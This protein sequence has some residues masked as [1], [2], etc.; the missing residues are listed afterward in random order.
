MAELTLDTQLTTQQLE[1]V[2]LIK[3]STF[4]LLTIINDILDFSKI[5]SGRFHLEEIPFSLRDTFDDAIRALA[6]QAAEKQVELIYDLRPDVPDSLIGDPGRLRQILNNLVGNA[7]KFTPEGEILVRVEM[8]NP[9]D[10]GPCTLHIEVRDTG[11]GIP[12]EKLQ[13]IFEAFRQVDSSTS[14]VYGGTGL[15]LAISS[16]LVEQM[17]G[18]MWVR[19][20]PGKGS[21][22]H[23]RVRLPTAPLDVTRHQDID[24]A[25]LAG[26]TALVIDDN[27]LNLEIFRETLEGWNIRVLSTTNAQAGIEQLRTAAAQGCPF[28][29]LLLDVVMPGMDG[30]EAARQIREEKLCERTATLMLSSAFRGND[31]DPAEFGCEFFLTKPVTR[32]ELLRAIHAALRLQAEPF[33]RPRPIAAANQPMHILLAEDNRVSAMVAR[34]MLEQRG[35]TVITAKNGAEAVRFWLDGEF[36]IVLMDMHMPDMDGDAATREIRRLELQRGGHIPI[37]AQTANAMGDAEQ[38]CLAAG[39]DAFITKPIIREKFLAVVESFTPVA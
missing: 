36:D 20:D 31:L 2:N 28:D 15:G 30:F 27:T 38:A 11:I 19:S 16:R 12:P 3:A 14:R 1:Y 23:V 25:A 37:V 13:V 24:P 39:M 7:I 33:V 21:S 22:F 29:L 35:H 8:A 5:E 6:I 9:R 34:R 10:P 4:S 32:P 26:H 17:N 18:R